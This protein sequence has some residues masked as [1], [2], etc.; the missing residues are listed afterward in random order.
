MRPLERRWPPEQPAKKT[1]DCCALGIDGT[2]RSRYVQPFDPSRCLRFLIE[3][4]FSTSS[5]VSRS[6]CSNG[7]SASSTTSRTW[8]SVNVGDI[9]TRTATATNRTNDR[10]NNAHHSTAKF[11][12][13][14]LMVGPGRESSRSSLAVVR[15]QLAGRSYF[16]G[17]GPA[18]SKSRNGE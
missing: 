5:S 1:R 17:Y 6:S 13:V 4:G 18:T 8:L 15:F 11:N 12:C 3:R 16:P 10:W 9:Q 7:D 2:G 14:I